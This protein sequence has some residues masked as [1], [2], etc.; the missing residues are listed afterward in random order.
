MHTLPS[1]PSTHYI[2]NMV[3]NVCACV[4]GSSA[5]V[6]GRELLLH[7][8]RLCCCQADCRSFLR[9]IR[10]FAISLKGASIFS[11][12]PVYASIAITCRHIACKKRDA[13][14]SSGDDGKQHVTKGGE[15]LKPRFHSLSESAVVLSLYHFKIR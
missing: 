1:V 8:Y 11:F 9:F 5:R 14:Y 10:L 12:L 4:N 3:V 7:P 15:T 6:V 13:Y 2:D